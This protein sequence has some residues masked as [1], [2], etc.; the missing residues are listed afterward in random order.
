[1]QEGFGGLICTKIFPPHGPE[2]FLI[3]S[4]NNYG[5][6]DDL[7]FCSKDENQNYNATSTWDGYTNTKNLCLNQGL[8]EQHPAA[9]FCNKLNIDGYC[10]WYLPSRDELEFIYFYLKPTHQ[11]NCNTEIRNFLRHD[12][13]FFYST[14]NPPCILE[15]PDLQDNI[16]LKY[17]CK[18]PHYWSSTDLVSRK[19][20][21]WRQY[22][23]DG[24]QVNPNGLKTSRRTVR[25]VRRHYLAKE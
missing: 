16:L 18:P 1:M 4:S 17:L 5:E 10:D 14:N 21:A 25:A 2:Y 20:D 11:I 24:T 6:K 9:N 3:L 19:N 22:F 12:G 7:M 8:S 15:S 13:I 23:T